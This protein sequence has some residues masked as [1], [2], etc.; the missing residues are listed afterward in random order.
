MKGLQT[1]GLCAVLS[2]GAASACAEELQWRPAASAPASSNLVRTQFESTPSPTE[3]PAFRPVIRAQKADQDVSQPLPS[4]PI[5]LFAQE[6]K[7]NPAKSGDPKNK[8]GGATL[9]IIPIN[10]RVIT[11]TPTHLS[12][13]VTILNDPRAVALDGGCDPCLVDC[14]E[15]CACRPCWWFRAEYLLWRLKG[16]QYPAL[17]TRGNT[18]NQAVLGADGTETLL[19]DGGF[20]NPLHSGARFSAGFW[21]PS[22]DC[23]GFEASYFFLGKRRQHFQFGSD[24]DNVIGRPFTEVNPGVI[25]PAGGVIPA[26]FDRVQF[27]TVP[28]VLDGTVKVDTYS[29]LW[30]VEANLRHK[31]WCGPCT[32]FDLI[33]GYRHTELS[34]GLAVREDLRT[35]SPIFFGGA[36]LPAGT[37]FVV[38]DRFETRN[39][40]HGGQVG[41]EGEYRFLPRWSIGGFAK[42]ALGNVRQQVVISGSTFESAS[43]QEGTGGLLTSTTNIG[44]IERNRFA[45]MPEGGLRL[46]FDVTDHLRLYVGYNFLYLSDVVRPGEQVD[47]KVNT[48]FAPFATSSQVAVQQGPRNP[49]VLFRTSDFWAQGVNFGLEYHW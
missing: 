15:G 39:R 28:G 35:L 21:L 4:G 9:E 12:G 44:R 48:G 11:A 5:L 14:W 29:R 49:A 13:P 43:G 33:Y 38:Q 23:L 19:D 34:E 46:N 16:D 45:V 2:W 24:S 7:K 22:W 25:G 42:V 17:V 10:P 18:T 31:L 6:S 37:E 26:P 40:F 3:I 20:D 1:A 8:D 30:G 32:W 27:V 41:V 47:T 36:V